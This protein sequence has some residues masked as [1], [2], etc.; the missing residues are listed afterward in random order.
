[1]SCAIPN[2]V[3]GTCSSRF[4]S[5]L[6]S[7]GLLALVAAIV[8]ACAACM[9]KWVFESF[10]AC[11]RHKWF[12]RVEEWLYHNDPTWSWPTRWT[13]RQR[14]LPELRKDPRYIA[15]KRR[16]QRCVLSLLIMEAIFTGMC[17]AYTQFHYFQYLT[18]TFT[19]SS[20]QW[21]YLSAPD[22]PH[23]VLGVQQ[24]ASWAEIRKAYRRISLKCHPEMVIY[25]SPQHECMT[26]M[27]RATAAWDILSNHTLKVASDQLPRKPFKQLVLL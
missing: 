26:L 5:F 23:Q 10:I 24:N 8:V 15:M 18:S 2:G 21:Q 14:L 16:R 11:M 20:K 12:A 13:L 17:M 27:P 7:L 9:A 25:R 4:F 19:T 1:M 3:E 6:F 22:D